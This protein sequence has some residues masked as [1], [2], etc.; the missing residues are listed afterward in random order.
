MIRKRSYCSSTISHISGTLCIC[1]LSITS[2]EFGSGHG[3]IW[4]STPHTKLAN[5]WP[6]KAWSITLRWMMP[7]KE[8]AGRIEYLC[9]ITGLFPFL[10]W[11][12]ILFTT[13][14]EV[15]SPSMVTSRGLCIASAQWKT[16][17][18][19]FVCKNQVFGLEVCTY[20]HLVF[21]TILLV[22]F[23]CWSC[24]LGK[25]GYKFFDYWS[26]WTIPSSLKIHDDTVSW[27]L[28]MGTHWCGKYVVD[29]LQFQTLKCQ[30]AAQ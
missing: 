23:H 10:K 17:E 20:K 24:H 22:L 14:K 18:V 1:T 11:E 19:A 26:G 25:L 5:S 6:L 13:N 30:A 28:L 15:A 2:T 7:S 16:I 12:C 21:C 9:K 3:C 27:E 4:S 29:I 8:I